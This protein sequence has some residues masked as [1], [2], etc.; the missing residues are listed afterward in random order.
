MKK[1]EKAILHIG[2][3][4]TG[5][6]SIQSALDRNRRKLLETGWVAYPPGRWHALLGS[7]LNDNPTS[8]FF[9]KELGLEN[10]DKIISERD[11]KYL[12]EL[13][14]WIETVPPCQSLVISYEG[15]VHLDKATFENLKYFLEKYA[16]EV[17][18]IFYIRPP[19]SY[20][21]SAISQRIKSGRPSTSGGAPP[22]QKNKEKIK[23]VENVFGK[24]KIKAIK[25]D[26][27][28][29]KGKDIV[30]DFLYNLG[31]SDDVFQK[32]EKIDE[33][34]DS[35][36]DKAIFVGDSVIKKMRYDGI[37]NA[38]EGFHFYD[39]VG[40][41]LSGYSGGKAKLDKEQVDLVLE[42]AKEES[43]FFLESYSI[44]LDEN[45]E[46]YYS[47]QLAAKNKDISGEDEVICG[48][49]KS[50]ILS[51][52]RSGKLVT[53][54]EKIRLNKGESIKL[55]ANILN[56]STAWYNIE[57]NPINASYH[58][59]DDKGNLY[60]YEGK[61]TPVMAHSIPALGE[62]ELQVRIEA[63]VVSGEYLVELTM[64][65]EGNCW[66]ENN[67][68]NSGWIKMAVQ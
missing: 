60:D 36:S 43:N 41:H 50:F 33:E 3:D 6:S 14:A 21:L 49:V 22:V 48:M 31:V 42:G 47:D 45:I 53:Q 30:C 51:G 12:N 11:D 9:N 58:I 54:E 23:D 1:F 35:L 63:P 37:L 46:D 27:E 55:S 18:V 2:L 4:K 68:F 39:L 32:L 7:A 64:V 62:I 57:P 56:T 28:S 25:F 17:F 65:Q 26:R 20:S 52:S 5:S 34:N 8:Y 40:K 15:F 29:L 10:Q 61:R 24:N 67:G 16:N 59:Y 13:N 38:L 66:F 44:K 19:L